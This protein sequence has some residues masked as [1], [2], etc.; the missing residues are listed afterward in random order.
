MAFLYI[1]GEKA[2]L[3]WNKGK[4]FNTAYHYLSERGKTLIST[5]ELEHKLK[6]PEKTVAA[7]SAPQPL[8]PLLDELV[9][10]SRKKNGK[11]RS[12]RP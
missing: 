12:Q 8:V 1:N 10:S 6:Q 3:T 5:A 4:G 9:N 2:G 7:W 11:G